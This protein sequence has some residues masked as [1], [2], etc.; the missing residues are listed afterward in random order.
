MTSG[1]SPRAPIK[2]RTR[3][4]PSYFSNRYAVW[5]A[6]LWPWRLQYCTQPSTHPEPNATVFVGHLRNRTGE[7]S[8]QGTETEHS[9]SSSKGRLG[10][11]RVGLFG[12]HRRRQ[13]VGRGQS[14]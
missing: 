3:I 4:R 2:G 8:L 12:W 14:P 11:S 1:G 5:Y 13:S 7:H 6:L 10:Y 9:G